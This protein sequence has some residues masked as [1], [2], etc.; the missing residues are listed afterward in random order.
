LS[1]GVGDRTKNMFPSINIVEAIHS[2][3]LIANPLA[4][5]ALPFVLSITG[6]SIAGYIGKGIIE[7]I[8]DKID[9][10]FFEKPNMMYERNTLMDLFGVSEGGEIFER[11]RLF[12]DLS[13]ETKDFI[14]PS[15]AGGRSLSNVLMRNHY[16]RSINSQDKRFIQ[17]IGWIGTG[18]KLN[19][20]PAN[21]WS[22]TKPYELGSRIK[23]YNSN[24]KKYWNDRYN[25][26]S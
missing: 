11:N 23:Q 24:I 4:K 15:F 17:G 22:V 2:I 26:L 13:P 20:L 16:E 19:P 5:A 8:S 9:W 1:D 25:N 14:M 6:I 18:R 3:Y 12:Q 10:E 21:N 7:A